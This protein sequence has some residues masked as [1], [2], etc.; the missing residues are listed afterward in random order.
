MFEGTKYEPP[1]IFVTC[2]RTGETHK[3]LV[4]SDGAVAHDGVRLDRDDA[5]RA[6]I[7]YLALRAQTNAGEFVNERAPPMMRD[8]IAFEESRER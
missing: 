7:A 2:R 4:G 8:E 1:L 3:L 6:A 5:R